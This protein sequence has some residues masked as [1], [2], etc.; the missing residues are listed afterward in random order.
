[1]DSLL[2]GLLAH[3]SALALD[4]GWALESVVVLA[5]ESVF[6][7]AAESVVELAAESVFQ[8]AAESVVELAAESAG[9]LVPLTLLG[10]A[11]EMLVQSSAEM[12]SHQC[13]LTALSLRQQNSRRQH[14]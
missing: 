7:S 13:G 11:H 6:Q 1:M 12:C 8:S 2:V 10:R 5:A 14:R 3:S 9:E 4:S